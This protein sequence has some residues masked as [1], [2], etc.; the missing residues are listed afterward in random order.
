[1]NEIDNDFQ[2]NGNRLVSVGDGQSVV[3]LFDS[4]LFQMEMHPL[5]LLLKN[6]TWKSSLQ[7][8]SGQSQMLWSRLPF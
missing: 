6:W 8:I 2:T 5:E 3:E 4:F 7:N 1:M